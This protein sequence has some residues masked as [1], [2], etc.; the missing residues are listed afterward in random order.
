M[1]FENTIFYIF[2]CNVGHYGWKV[3][4]NFKLPVIIRVVN[5]QYLNY[6]CKRLVESKLCYNLNYDYLHENIFKYIS[7]KCQLMSIAEAKLLNDINNED[8][9]QNLG[10]ELFEAG[11]DSI[12]HEDAVQELYTFIEICYNKL[13]Y[14]NSRPN[15][16]KCGYI[17][18][19]KI[20]VVPYCIIDNQKYIPLFCFDDKNNC[21]MDRAIKI[22]NWDFAY[23]KLCL[24]IL[25]IK[26]TSD[27]IYTKKSCIGTTLEVIMKNFTSNA[28]FEEYFPRMVK[29]IQLQ[30]NVNSYIAQHNW[31]V[32]HYTRM[33]NN[34]YYE[35]EWPSNQMVRDKYLIFFYFYFKS[36]VLES[37]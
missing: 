31:S 4:G 35:N 32:P 37:I 20:F 12:V 2:V 19:N 16:E 14:I 10:I 34:N 29:N 28:S 3:F 30:T 5:G 25:D 18:I 9:S 8:D 6:I 22:K 33:I 36:I 15:N 26:D 24:L 21:L 1:A 27:E 23:I 13:V 7:V 11:Q 17:L